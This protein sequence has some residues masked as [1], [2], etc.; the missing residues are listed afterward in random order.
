MCCINKLIDEAKC[1]DEIRTRRWSYGVPCPHCDSHWIRKRGK[2]HRQQEGRR[3][4]CKTCGK[5]FDELTGTIFLGHPQP[6]SVGLTFLYLRGLNVSNQQIAQ[7]RG[8]DPSDGQAMAERLRGGSVQRRPQVRMRGV[9]EDDEVSVVAGHKGRPDPI[10]GRRGRRRRLKG[11]PGRGALAQ[12]KPPI[13]G[14]MERGGAVGIIMLKNGQQS[15]I[16]PLIQETIE[17]G[18]IINTDEY[19]IDDA[20]THWGDV[21]KSVCHSAGE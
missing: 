18:P 16:R 14:M 5:R 8:L 6:L 13:F 7:A 2:H 11:A 15:T 3:Y 20:L 21:R 12:E 17:P 1:Y 19:V 4:A 9:V 10:K